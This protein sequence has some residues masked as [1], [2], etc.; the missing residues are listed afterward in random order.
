MSCC[1]TC[2]SSAMHPAALNPFIASDNCMFA[3]TRLS[4]WG[5]NCKS[6][7]NQGFFPP[8]CDP[9]S[10]PLQRIQTR[11][12][13]FSSSWHEGLLWSIWKTLEWATG[14]CLLSGVSLSADGPPISMA[15]TQQPFETTETTVVSLRRQTEIIKGSKWNPKDQC[16]ELKSELLLWTLVSRSPQPG[17]E[18]IKWSLDVS[19]STS[20]CFFSALYASGTWKCHLKSPGRLLLYI[21]CLPSL[22]LMIESPNVLKGISIMGTTLF[23]QGRPGIVYKASGS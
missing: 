13:V 4:K 1:F 11:M 12:H 9:E 2:T 14:M 16:E 15:T 23:S 7:R 19:L 5:T 20:A 18:S 10:W 21:K 8:S 6:S 17:S 3:L 22:K